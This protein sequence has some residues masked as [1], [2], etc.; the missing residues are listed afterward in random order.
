MFVH[1]CRS[2]TLDS[3]PVLCLCISRPNPNLGLN[4]IFA[5]SQ[6]VRKLRLEPAFCV[7]LPVPN[8]GLKLDLSFSL[9]QR[10]PS[11]YPGPSVANYPS[12]KGTPEQTTIRVQGISPPGVPVGHLRSLEVP[13]G[14]LRSP[15]SPWRNL[16]LNRGSRGAWSS[17]GAAWRSL[18]LPGSSWGS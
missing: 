10:A 17:V 12:N 4:L 13:G 16:E 18:E 5:L 2:S 1:L 9:C 8:L 7:S 3:N 6:L 15:E 14:H 11:N